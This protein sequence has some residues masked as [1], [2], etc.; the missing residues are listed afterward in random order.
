MS[1]GPRLTVPAFL[2][3]VR[4]RLP[5]TYF[6]HLF[7]APD[8]GYSDQGVRRRERTIRALQL[9]RSCP[10]MRPCRQWAREH[11]EYGV[12]G[13]ETDRQRIV[14]GHAVRALQEGDSAA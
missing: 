5:C 13:G 7:H 14:T 9:C 8:D 12:W 1:D 10:V 3:R 2:T 6:P 4:T 11:G